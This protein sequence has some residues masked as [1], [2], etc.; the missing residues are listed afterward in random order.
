MK[1]LLWKQCLYRSVLVFLLGTFLFSSCKK[2]SFITS[3]DAQLYTSADTISFDTVF[4][5]VGS[6]SKSFKIFNGNNQKLLLSDVQLAGGQSSPFKINI[7]GVSSSSVKNIELNP[8]DSLYVFVQVNVDPNSEKNPFILKDSIEISFNGNKR[9]VQLQAYGQNAIFLKREVIRGHQIWTNEL[10]YVIVGSV[11]VDTNATLNIE[12]GTKIYLHADAP[13]LVDGQLR[14]IGTKD[15]RIIF[16]GDRMDDVYKDLPAGWPGLYFRN[17]SQDNVL[18]YAIIKNAYQGI[19]ARDRS[20]TANPK[21]TLSKCIVENIYDIGILGINTEIYADNCLVSNCGTNVLLS[22]GGDYRFTF[23]TVVT[24]GSLYIDH[25][26]PVIQ[27]SDHI[28]S[29]GMIYTA[30]LNA[31]FTNSIFWGE[32]GT[33]EN[34]LSVVKKGTDFF[35]VTF[36][37]VLYKSKDEVTN[38]NFIASIKN[39]PPGFD[40]VN[41]AKNIYDFRILN[42]PLSPA[43]GSGKPTSFNLDLDGKTRATTP[44]LGCY[45]R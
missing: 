30:P 35:D 5:T 7:D 36:D 19:V 18:E 33:V 42:N 27:V 4:T 1:T 37:H 3:P 15:S 29:G 20:T 9:F 21:L 6:I 12:A 31:T 38:A 40:S 34:E 8:N 23:C 13:F 11:Q 44:D 24:Y 25:K 41:T 14:A 45:E 26:N 22:Y 2:D 43:A 17:T 10:P 28:E 16:S 32:N 39:I